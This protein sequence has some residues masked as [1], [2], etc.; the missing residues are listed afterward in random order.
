M[1]GDRFWECLHCEKEGDLKDFLKVLYLWQGIP[2]QIFV[3]V[4][5]RASAIV[6]DIGEL[7]FIWL[8]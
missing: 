7:P 5:N 3:T 8:H 1:Q 6:T 2:Q 4:M